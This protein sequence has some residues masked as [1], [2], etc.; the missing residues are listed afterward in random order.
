LI[1]IRVKD[2]RNIKDAFLIETPCAYAYLLVIYLTLE[3]V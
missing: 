1:I 2:K 3:K